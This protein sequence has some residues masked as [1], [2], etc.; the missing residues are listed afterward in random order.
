MKYIFLQYM[1]LNDQLQPATKVTDRTDTDNA[2]FDAVESAGK[3]RYGSSQCITQL[4][5]RRL[6]TSHRKIAALGESRELAIGIN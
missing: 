1:M 2:L 6:G 4:L 5:I 3:Q